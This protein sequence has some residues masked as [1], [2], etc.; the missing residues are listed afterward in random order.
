[1]SATDAT[2]RIIPWI[3]DSFTF[4]TYKIE[5]PD[6]VENETHGKKEKKV[7]TTKQMRDPLTNI[8]ML[9][10]TFKIMKQV[11]ISIESQRNELSKALDQVKLEM[12]A[13]IDMFTSGDFNY[14]TS[15]DPTAELWKKFRR[16][17]EIL[18]K[19]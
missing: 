3:G 13:N 4:G 1:M 11:V 6:T 15:I 8:F 18:V 16:I 19:K 2:S 7:V 9:E 5:N 14:S 10:Q 17:L 12:Q